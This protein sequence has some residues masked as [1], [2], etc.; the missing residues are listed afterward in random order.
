MRRIRN[1]I[2]ADSA[3]VVGQVELGD[4][5]NV[6]YG[7]AIRGDIARIF[8]GRGTNVQENAVIHIDGGLDS[9]IGED[10]TIG[11][12][13]IV[14][15]IA[16]GDGSLIGMGA[17]LLGRTRVGKRCLIGAGALVPPGMEVPDDSL[18]V[19]VPGRVVRPL[20][21]QEREYIR[22]AG[23]HYVENSR[24]HADHPDDPRVRPFGS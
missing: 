4:D 14:H 15:G 2:I 21:A 20:N 18:V 22:M 16:I 17:V 24:V 10:V 12:G 8:I 1:V 13:A 19:G 6:W 23:P 11:H 5:V 7:A 9:H 3:R